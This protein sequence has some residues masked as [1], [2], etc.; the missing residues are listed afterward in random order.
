MW[1]CA[2]CRRNDGQALA[3]PRP[4]CL[5]LLQSA[6]QQPI[7][8]VARRGS[9]C[10]EEAEDEDLA[11]LYTQPASGARPWG[12]GIMALARSVMG[13]GSWGPSGVVTFFLP[14]ILALAGVSRAGHGA[15]ASQPALQ[16]HA[17]QALHFL[18]HLLQQLD[19]ATKPC[20][21]GM[22]QDDEAGEAGGAFSISAAVEALRPVAVRSSYGR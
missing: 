7:A 22:A 15:G 1:A 10:S 14:S 18:V 20:A 21:T 12:D 9:G 16:G 13:D 4:T 6:L 2:P 11:L 19:H 3:D 5:V 8:F 17:L